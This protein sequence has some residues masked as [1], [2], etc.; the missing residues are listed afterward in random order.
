MHIGGLFRPSVITTITVERVVGKER[1]CW[2]GSLSFFGSH[3]DPKVTQFHE[4]YLIM[5]LTRS[6][7]CSVLIFLLSYS[8]SRV[9][10]NY[11]V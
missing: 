1:D 11:R 10:L 5:S 9:D 6:F 7:R 3:P 4:P 8:Y 2:K